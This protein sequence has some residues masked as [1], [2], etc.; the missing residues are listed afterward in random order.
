[1]N[2]LA[3]AFTIELDIRSFIL[4]PD[5]PKEGRIKP[6]GPN[7]L[8]ATLIQAAEEL[9]LKMKSPHF[10]PYTISALELTELS[11]QYGLAGTFQIAMY[12]AYWDNQEDIGNAAV[13]ER[14]ALNI[15]LP[16]LS[17]RQTIK[18]HSFLPKVIE[19]HYQA[20]VLGFKGIP[21][22]LIGKTRFV[23]AVDTLRLQEA[24]KNELHRIT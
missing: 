7:Q 10:I 3:K 22:I 4:K 17:V 14:I 20:E 18:N 1:M 8:P 2:E 11:K 6:S 16:R 23:G 21:A 12:S 15:G 24:V 19:Q 9:G 13:L 5:I